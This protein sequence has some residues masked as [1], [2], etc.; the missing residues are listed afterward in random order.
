MVSVLSWVSCAN[1]F[2]QFAGWAQQMLHNL[3]CD[4]TRLRWLLHY[5]LIIPGSQLLYSVLK[6]IKIKIYWINPKIFWKRQKAGNGI[7]AF[8]EI[9]RKLVLII[10]F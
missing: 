5:L 2:P 8:S 3:A 1:E 10:V 9:N 7:T 4:N 6:F